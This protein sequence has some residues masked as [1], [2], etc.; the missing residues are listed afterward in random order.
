MRK[1]NVAILGTGKIGFDLLLKV[2][3]SDHL[4]CLLF[5]G[6]RETSAGLS[7]ARELNIETS[8][9]GIDSIIR[10]SSNLDLVFDAT[11]AQS[12]CEHWPI[13]KKLSL[14]TIDLTP[15]RVGSMCIP[16][17]NMED[18]ITK[19]NINMVTCGGQAAIPI[20][21]AASSVIEDIQ[22]IET[23]SAIASKSAGPATRLNIDEYLHTTEKG[24]SFFTGCMPTK[25][26]LNLNPAEYGTIMQTSLY[27]KAPSYDLDL[28]RQQVGRIVA[29][30]QSYAPGFRMILEPVIENSRLVIIIQMKALSDCLPVYAGNVEIINCA[31]IAAA[32][33]FAKNRILDYGSNKI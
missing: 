22:Y 8:I 33:A 19:E 9:Q 15:A 3:K 29:K 1:L 5:A 20:A 4:D 12:H 14:K 17:I 6:R 11:S 21:H 26:I 13:L 27:I 24:L 2:K 16:A 18:S 23:V 30:I 28:I 32:E 10:N 25:A 7:H 31:A